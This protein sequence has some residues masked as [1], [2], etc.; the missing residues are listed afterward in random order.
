MQ[1]FQSIQMLL[2][3]YVAEDKSASKF[4]ASKANQKLSVASVRRF[5]NEYW[6]ANDKQ[7]DKKF[8]ERVLSCWVMNELIFR[9]FK[10]SV[11]TQEQ[12]SV[13]LKGISTS[14]NCIIKEIDFSTSVNQKKILFEFKCHI[15]LVE[16][17][18]YK[19]QLLQE[20]LPKEKFYT[21]LIVWDWNDKWFDKEGKVC[22]YGKL[23]EYSKAQGCLNEFLYLPGYKGWDGN[24]YI[25]RS[26]IEKEIR[27]LKDAL[28]K[29]SRNK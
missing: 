6:Y 19:Y 20:C 24:A 16:K 8:S 11:R 26:R 14:E 15:D 2:D 21:F 13:P 28:L 27:K 29:I 18:L 1:E 4:L 17:D 10:N 12:I 3:S 9:G 23:L 5:I 22:Q 25:N 7:R